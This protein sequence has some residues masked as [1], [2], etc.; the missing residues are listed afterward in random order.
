MPKQTKLDEHAVIYQPRQELSEKEKLKDMN[1]AEKFN[2]LWEYYRIHAAIAVASIA[3]I[4]YIVHEIMTPDVV[5]QFYAAIIDSGVPSETML[6][7]GEDFAEYLE[8]D[9]TRQSIELSD[10]FYSSSSDYA[11]SMQQIL[12]TYIAAGE[13]DV[14]I[15]PESEFM[16]YA[17]YGY[18]GKLSDALPTDVYSALT[19]YFY[20][21]ETEEDATKN[22]YGINLSNSDLFQNLEYDGEPYILGIVANYPHADN[23][24]EFIRYLFGKR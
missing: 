21:T 15:A 9:P 4:I 17:Y 18:F 1:V 8:L 11:S 20:I 5:P 19:D 13:V 2:Y 22:A 14:I 23:T 12:A 10:K 6:Q 16:N 3:L 24:V 7:Y